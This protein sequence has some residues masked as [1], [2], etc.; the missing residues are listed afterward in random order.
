MSASE[1]TSRLLKFAILACG[2]GIG[3]T[4]PLLIQET[5]YTFTAFMFLGQPLLLLAFVLFAIKVFRDL[6]SRGLL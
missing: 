2:L 6:H 5:P 3:L 1:A 4:L